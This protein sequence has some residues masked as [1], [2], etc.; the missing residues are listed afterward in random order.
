MVFLADN[1]TDFSGFSAAVFSLDLH[2]PDWGTAKLLVLC[3]FDH[4]VMAAP[5][6]TDILVLTQNVAVM[7][8]IAVN[9]YISDEDK[10]TSFAYKQK[11]WNWGLFRKIASQVGGKWGGILVSQRAL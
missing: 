11:G 4:F 2:W 3:I 8:P 10:I 9:Q 1:Y 5:R 6:G 7:G